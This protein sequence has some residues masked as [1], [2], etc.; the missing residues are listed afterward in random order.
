MLTVSAPLTLWPSLDGE[1]DIGSIS[2]RGAERALTGAFEARQVGPWYSAHEKFICDGSWVQVKLEHAR[3]RRLTKPT[4][5]RPDRAHSRPPPLGGKILKLVHDRAVP[6]HRC[7]GDSPSY[8]AATISRRRDH[9]LPK[10]QI[11]F[12]WLAEIQRR[13][14]AA[15]GTPGPALTADTAYILDSIGRRSQSG[16]RKKIF[17]ALRCRLFAAKASQ[18][19]LS[20]RHEEVSSQIFD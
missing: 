11:P 2:C 1:A 5:F 15:A 3:E 6:A 16:M 8:A 9:S 10:R 17:A 19:I 12:S 7:V 4:S 20:N 14:I 18:E 13:P